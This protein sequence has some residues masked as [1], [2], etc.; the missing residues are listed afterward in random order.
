MEYPRLG[1]SGLEISRIALGCVSFGDKSRG[2]SSWALDDEGA[3]PILKH[4]V[5]AGI[6]LWDTANVCGDLVVGEAEPTGY[7]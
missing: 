2:F 7:A 5:D 6:N 4:A 3:A 1:G